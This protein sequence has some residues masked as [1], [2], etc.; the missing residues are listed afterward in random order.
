MGIDF[1]KVYH[2]SSKDGSRGHFPILENSDNWPESWKIQEYKVY[3]RFPKIPLSDMP[4]QKLPAN[5]FH[6]VSKRRSERDYGANQS[7]LIDEIAVLLR[8]SCGISERKVFP[9]RAQPSAGERFPIEMYIFVLVPG[10]NLPAGLYHYDVKSHRLDVLRQNVLTK[11]D[12]RRLFRFE[13]VEKASAVL[14]MTTVFGRNQIKYGDRGYRYILI[15]AGHI[16]QNISLVSLALDLKC[17]ALGGTRDQDIEE[18]LDIDG[19]N[20]SV[21][22]AFSIGR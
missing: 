12:I 17:C 4:I 2:Q 7:L 10:K 20:E 16:G 13:W 15:E 5:F 19:I 1:S 9:G 8:Y 22:Y 11:E 18:F 3:P 14:V 21:V 6:L